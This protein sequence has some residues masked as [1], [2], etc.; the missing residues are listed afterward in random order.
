MSLL[1]AYQVLHEHCASLLILLAGDDPEPSEI[2]NQLA[3]LASLQTAIAAEPPPTTDEERRQ[4]LAIA[5]ECLRL[6]PAV[7]TAAAE[8]RDRL[9]AAHMREERA[10]QGL[11]AYRDGPAS[12]PA[13][14]ID[15]QR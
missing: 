5:N 15:Q 7:S 6:T 8:C 13:N 14:F 3:I 2:E 10:K 1:S 12:G 4:V 9:H 11:N